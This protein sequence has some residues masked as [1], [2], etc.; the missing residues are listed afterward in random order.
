MI[1][2]YHNSDINQVYQLEKKTFKEP[3]LESQ[4]SRYAVGL[5]NSM[6]YTYKINNKVVGYLMAESIL[7]EIHIHNIVVKEK[8]RNNNIAKEM[9]SCLVL[10][11]KKSHKNRVCLEVNCSNIFALKLYNNLGF[12]KVGVR[13]KYYRDGM[14]AILMNLPI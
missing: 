5:N 8:Y 12:K 14:D 13:K 4:F 2:S 7:D 9:I 10:E 11:G 1:N 6:S 3:W